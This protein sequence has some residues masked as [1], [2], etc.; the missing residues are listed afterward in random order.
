MTT[1]VHRA[2]LA[3]RSPPGLSRSRTTLPGGGGDRGDTAESGPRRL[4][5][6]PVGVVAGG[7]NRAAAESMP[8]PYSDSRSS[9]RSWSSWVG[10]G[11][12]RR[13][14]RR[15]R[16]PADPER[17]ARSWWR[18]RPG[19]CRRG[20]AGP[21]CAWPPSGGVSP[22]RAWR[23]SSGAVKPRWRIWLRR[24]DLGGLGRAFGHHQRPDRF[25]VAVAGLGQ[26]QLAFTLSGAS[27]LDGIKSVGLALAPPFLTVG[28]VDLD[29]RHPD[30]AQLAGQRR[31]VGA[32]ALHP[33]LVNVAEGGEPPS[34]AWFPAGL[35]G[36]DS[37]PNRP[38]MPSSAAATL[39]SRW[40]ST[41]PVTG[42]EVSTIVTAIPAFHCAVR[43]GTA[44]LERPVDRPVRAGR[45]ATIQRQHHRP[46]LADGSFS[47]QAC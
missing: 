17:A 26:T 31:P 4:R 39:R 3:R 23:I 24:G 27:R 35:V 45:S 22:A 1:M 14:R 28:P 47:R 46:G 10:A 12:S 8:T 9:W 18:E 43:G 30:P 16:G 7:D 5:A 41:P 40:V 37:T 38:P 19:R 44:A 32:G 33:H 20:G 42:R 6:Q 34:N 11:R 15:G 2:A 36:N 13:S 21:P 29:H 25:D